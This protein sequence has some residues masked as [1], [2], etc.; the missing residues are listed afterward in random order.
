MSGS[1]Q[2]LIDR[3]EKEALRSLRSNSGRE[4]TDFEESNVKMESSSH[5]LEVDDGDGPTETVLN[6]SS[7]TLELSD[8]SVSQEASESD[9][10]D[11]DTNS[12]A[13]AVELSELDSDSDSEVPL[14]KS[15]SK[16]HAKESQT[17]TK[18]SSKFEP[19]SLEWIL[20]TTFG[21]AEFRPGQKWAIER[22]L[23]ARRSLLVMPTGAGKSLCYMLPS[24]LIEGTN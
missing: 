9:C 7:G 21:Y 16:R 19:N 8:S 5:F 2:D 4:I 6:A 18:F 1:R 22:C 12:Q 14:K 3:L 23:S 17:A 13:N 10:D 15:S 24:L 11:K 20:Q